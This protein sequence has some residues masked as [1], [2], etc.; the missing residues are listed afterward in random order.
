[1]DIILAL[2]EELKVE[3]WQGE[4]VRNRRKGEEGAGGSCR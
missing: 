3:K 4:A 1:M 2:T